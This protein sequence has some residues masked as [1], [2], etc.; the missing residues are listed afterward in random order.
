MVGILTGRFGDTSNRPY[1]EGRL[2]LPELQLHADL[3]FLVD[4]GADQTVVMPID[5]TRMGLDYT[6]LG[7]Q[8][9]DDVVGIGGATRV[10]HQ[11]AIVVFSEARRRLYC[12]SLDVALV[13]PDVGNGDIPSLLGR[14]VLDR[15]QMTYDPQK[16][17]LHFLVRSA[18][19]TIS[20]PSK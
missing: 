5:G 15:W 12:Y 10:F 19:T 17:D 11:Y 16:K 2:Y 13:G 7:G 8:S 20:I 6:R 3:S 18:D 9:S 4:T 1:L 14:A